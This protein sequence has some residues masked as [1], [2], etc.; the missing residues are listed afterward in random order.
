MRPSLGKALTGAQL[1]GMNSTQRI[2]FWGERVITVNFAFDFPSSYE[3][4]AGT[5]V[6]ACA[7]VCVCACTGMH[8]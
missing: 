3:T 7:R 4:E 5:H 1:T 8:T 2:A 6:C